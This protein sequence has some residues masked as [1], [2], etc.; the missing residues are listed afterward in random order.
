MPPNADPRKS[1]KEGSVVRS[2]FERE[3]GKGACPPAFSR[4]VGMPQ[5]K[6]AESMRIA[7][8]GVAHFV[9]PSDEMR[10]A[11]SAIHNAAAK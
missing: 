2:R 1:D 9:S 5:K 10:R 6:D 11:Q 7:S 3:L 4:S 8:V